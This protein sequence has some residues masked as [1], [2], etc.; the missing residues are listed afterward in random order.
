MLIDLDFNCDLA[1]VRVNIGDP[2]GQY[3]S[4]N[5]VT[6]ALIASDNDVV[7]ASILCM[8]ALKNH[9]STLADKEKVGEVEVEYKRLYERYKQLLD[10][11]V[12][13]NT[14]RYSAG[15]YIG[16][17]SLSERNRVLEDEDVFTGF[18]QADWTDI[19]QSRRVLKEV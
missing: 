1:K 10:D 18:D 9:F 6:S 4:D 11:F 17:T 15:I 13:A 8:T 7:K 16:G 19:M 5:A 14:S 3:I 2:T 12:R